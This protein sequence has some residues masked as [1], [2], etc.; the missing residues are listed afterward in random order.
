MM[1][2]VL[3]IDPGLRI[4]GFALVEAPRPDASPRLVDAGHLKLNA[5][6]PL[7]ERL[8]E[9]HREILELI[10]ELAPTRLAAE[11]LYSHYEHPTTA[12]LMGH[13]RGVILLAGALRDKPVDDLPST[14]VKK[15]LTG[16]GHASKQRMQHAVAA[17]FGLPAPPEPPD[18][19]DAIAIA[20][21]AVRRRTHPLAGT[22]RLR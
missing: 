11:K 14:E 7:P 1:T 4:T 22:P 9:L 18:V 16:D 2:R 10:D 19:A 13:A 17:Q 20:A 3:G 21:C 8:A 6:A 12:I 5:R 15:S